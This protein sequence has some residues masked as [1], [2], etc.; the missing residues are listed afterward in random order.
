MTILWESKIKN[1]MWIMILAYVEQYVSIA[2]LLG[3]QQEKL[4]INVLKVYKR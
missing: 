1:I 3:Y 4:N 2:G